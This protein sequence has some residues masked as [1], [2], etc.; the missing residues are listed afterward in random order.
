MMESNSCISLT[1]SA[2][3]FF[4]ELSEQDHRYAELT[5]LSSSLP[6]DSLS[7]YSTLS[8]S[9]K[10]SIG[11]STN[12]IR[13]ETEAV[14]APHPPLTATA[15]ELSK[16]LIEYFRSNPTSVPEHHAELSKRVNGLLARTPKDH[17]AWVI[18]ARVIC[19]HGA[20]E[21]L[22]KVRDRL[23]CLLRA[24]YH[25]ESIPKSYL[26]DLHIKQEIAKEA[27]L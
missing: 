6:S 11:S 27:G 18:A 12:S 1:E 4:Q 22:G 15:A 23:E 19:D 26:I 2:I 9:I 7:L 17:L 24:F 21:I 10:S 13:T 25:C 5:H 3:D 14:L 8:G 20:T 16:S